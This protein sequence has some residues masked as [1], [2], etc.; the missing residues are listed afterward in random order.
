[1][2]FFYIYQKDSIKTVKCINKISLR[3]IALKLSFLVK[4]WGF[5]KK[6]EIGR[7]VSYN[8]ENLRNYYDKTF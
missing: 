6:C 2:H 4:I 7:A 3:S 8:R 1:M 5:L